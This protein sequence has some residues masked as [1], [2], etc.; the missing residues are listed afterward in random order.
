[1]GGNARC[2]QS[3]KI[4]IGQI[5]PLNISIT[6]IVPAMSGYVPLERLTGEETYD[7]GNMSPSMT[8]MHIRQNVSSELDTD[9]GEGIEDQL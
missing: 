3:I 7:L 8:V 9:Q 2:F 4:L 5:Y 6:P 1:M